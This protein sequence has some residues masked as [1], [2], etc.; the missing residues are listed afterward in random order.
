MPET[1]KK[2][3]FMFAIIAFL[4][5]LMAVLLAAVS[6]DLTNTDKELSS[7]LGKRVVIENDTS[8]I[9]DYSILTGSYTLSNGKTISKELLVNKGIIIN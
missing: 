5:V 8:M 1:S 7:K 9:T 4:G 6:N 3:L 2:L